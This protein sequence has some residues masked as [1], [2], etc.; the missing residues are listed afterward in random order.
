MQ[1]TPG[2][3][4]RAGDRSLFDRIEA[5]V[6]EEGVTD[7]QR[8]QITAELSDIA[9]RTRA[10]ELMLTRLSEVLP[11]LHFLLSDSDAK[12]D[13][14]VRGLGMLLAIVSGQAG[15]SRRSNELPRREIGQCLP[16]W[17]ESATRSLP[18]DSQ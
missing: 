7:S 15:R 11:S 16:A 6:N 17:L 14:L 12:H 4:Y 3:L 18:A 8:L 9:E 13:R 5:A 10:P 2:E 1:V